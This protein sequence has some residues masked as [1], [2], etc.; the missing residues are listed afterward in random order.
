MCIKCLAALSEAE[1]VTMAPFFVRAGVYYMV[2]SGPENVASFFIEQY[3]HKTKS[4]MTAH[5]YDFGLSIVQY[6]FLNIGMSSCFMIRISTSP[7]GLHYH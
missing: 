2:C 3:L 4:L 6:I 7:Q 5:N 1:K